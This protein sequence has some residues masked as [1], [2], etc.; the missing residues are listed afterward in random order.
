MKTFEKNLENIVWLYQ[1]DLRTSNSKTSQRTRNPPNVPQMSQKR[2][3]NFKTAT[4]VPKAFVN[5]ETAIDVSKAL[6]N[7]KTATDVPKALVNQNHASS[8]INVFPAKIYPAMHVPKA[9]IINIYFPQRS[10]LSVV[11]KVFHSLH[12]GAHSGLRRGVR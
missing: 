5:F 2:L 11:N 1:S 12:C 10:W 8:K 4:N 6:V 3:V 7:F 9:F